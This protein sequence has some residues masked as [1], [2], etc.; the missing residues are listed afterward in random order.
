MYILHYFHY[1]DY[2][3]GRIGSINTIHGSVT[4]P[5]FVFCGTKGTIKG[6]LSCYFNSQ[7]LLCNAFH[8]KNH[9]DTI[10]QFGGLHKYIGWNKPIIMDSGGFQIFSM[11][12]GSV[13]SE[14]K[15]VRNKNKNYTKIIEEGCIFTDPNSGTKSLLSPEWSIETQYKLGA[16]LT[17]V[18]DECTASHSGYEYTKESM[19]RSHRWEL[20]SLKHFKELHLK[21][22]FQQTINNPKQFWN[23]PKQQILYGIVQGGTYT[24]LR[25]QS[26]DFINQNQDFNAIAIGGSL[27]KSKKEMYDIVTYTAENLDKSR[28]RHLL[29]IGRV[30]D[31]ITLAPYIDTFDCVEPT[32]IARHGMALIK[33]NKL[34]LKNQKFINDYNPIETDCQCDTCKNYSRSYISYLIKSHEIAGIQALVIHNIFF[35]N[36]LMEDIRHHISNNIYN[37]LINIYC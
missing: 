32:R 37:K 36:R 29:G 4:T 34:N 19:Y 12:Y 21:K 1:K 26:I 10:Y 5:A 3:N 30:E 2:K 20:R 22:P 25:N 18:F 9:S 16:D 33:K 11:G 31:I 6:L 28:P 8:L 13:A 17:I 27:G 24:D 15:G 14:I 23:G 7:I 35:M